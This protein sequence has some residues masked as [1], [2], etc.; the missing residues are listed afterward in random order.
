MN[1]DSPFP[2][3]P[4]SLEVI[5]GQQ[6]TFTDDDLTLLHHH[7]LK[8]RSFF[9]RRN[10]GWRV[11]FVKEITYV[12]R[13]IRAALDRAHKDPSPPTRVSDQL[14]LPLGPADASPK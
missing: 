4:A 12:N 2:P 11:L 6:F 14:P 7:L 8:A 1:G 10:T 3:P 5:V 13:I 9:E